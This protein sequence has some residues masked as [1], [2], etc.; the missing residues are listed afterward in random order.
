MAC[1]T[2]TL[3]GFVNDCAGSIGGVKKVHIAKYEEVAEVTV[4]EEKVTAIS[5][6]DNATFKNYYFKPNMA[7][8]VSTLNIDTANGNNYVTT[9][10]SM[11]FNK[12]ETTK[13]I[14]MS[15]LSKLEL[16]II[17]EDNNGIYWLMGRENPVTAINGTG[18]TGVVRTDANK[19]SITLQDF[20][21]TYLYEIDKSALESILG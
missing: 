20:S 19:Y 6:V 3:V 4:T 12:M 16:A 10:L 14:E 21:T 15:A 11:T 13:R 2:L 7:S 17:I 1:N 18:E 9:D 8:F 5:M